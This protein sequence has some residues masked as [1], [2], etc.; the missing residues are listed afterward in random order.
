[1]SKQKKTSRDPVAVRIAAEV[2]EELNQA[3]TGIDLRTIGNPKRK[4]ARRAAPPPRRN[5]TGSPADVQRPLFDL[6]Q[7]GAR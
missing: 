4:P 3:L 1:M 5:P 6:D 2:G 7:G